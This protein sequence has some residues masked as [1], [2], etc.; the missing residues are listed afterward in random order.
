MKTMVVIFT[1]KVLAVV[2]PHRKLS[3]FHVHW[4]NLNRLSSCL[5]YFSFFYLP[6]RQ[7]I[8]SVNVAAE[9]YHEGTGSSEKARNSRKK[10]YTLQ[11]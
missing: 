3:R 6:S 8:Y 7:S 5:F 2:A 9:R 11:L 1:G 4:R 10:N